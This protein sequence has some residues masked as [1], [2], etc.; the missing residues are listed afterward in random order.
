MRIFIFAKIVNYISS[1]PYLNELIRELIFTAHHMEWKLLYI[2]IML[3]IAGWS[4]DSLKKLFIR[5]MSETAVRS[6]ISLAKL[7]LHNQLESGR[8]LDDVLNWSISLSSFAFK[9]RGR[10]I[11]P[12]IEVS[13]LHF[14]LEANLV[15]QIWS[16]KWH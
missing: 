15:L 2:C 9:S 5:R 3:N 14:P 8:Y 11:L 13:R 7:N 12:F 10:I 6:Y 4:Y 1:G 16:F